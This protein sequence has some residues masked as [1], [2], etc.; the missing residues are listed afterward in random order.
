[1]SDQR[2]EAA[3]A[4]R[5]TRLWQRHVAMA[6][7]GAIP[8]N[9]VNRQCL[10]HE[11]IRARALLISWAKARGYRVLIDDIA[12]LFIHRKGEDESAAP[13]VTGSHMD[14]QPA[15][16]RFDGIYGVLAGLEAL[17]ALDDQGVRTRRPIEVVAWTNEE[18]G[19]F[20]PG[21]MGSA[22]FTGA[23]AL[24]DCL[25]ITDLVG[26]RFADALRDTLNATPDL[27]RRRFGTPLGA[28]I[29]AHIE[30]GPE[31][32]AKG[33]PIGVVTGIQG[34]RWYLVKVQ[35]EGA[36]AGTTP[37]GARQDA[38][39]SAVRIVTAL[40]EL[41]HDGDDRLR[42]TIGRF[43]VTPNSPNTVPE[44]VLFSIDF[45]HPDGAVLES[46]GDRIAEIC[47]RHAGPCTVS[48]AETFNRAPSIFAS[49]LVDA[50][51][52]AARTQSIGCQRMPSGA[53]HDANFLAEVCPTAMLFVPCE[54]GI[55]HNPAENAKP[56][57]LAAGA[58]VL[59]AALV[60][61]AGAA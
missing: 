14:S 28:Y 27:E 48:V 34:S 47:Q 25:E 55:S 38:L 26:V 17:E 39:R 23:R 41:M 61:L 52:R 2:L 46:R 20:S 51:E 31:L 50:L 30:Q 18:G 53:F 13:I 19:R 57:D 44:E 54:R 3:A 1:M 56:A 42:F 7:I 21:A 33:L 9:G 15:G 36:H 45:R 32:E 4:V 12:N 40:E 8:G 10:T 22:V 60:D 49:G 59:T 24:E 58:R 37:L 11:D 35:G 5:E 16:G 43:D 6:R 29:E